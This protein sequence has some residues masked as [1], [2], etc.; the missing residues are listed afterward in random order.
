MKEKEEKWMCT[1]DEPVILYQKEMMKCLSFLLP[2]TWESE[3]ELG[4]HKGKGVSLA[5]W[6]KQEPPTYE[7]LSI[8][9]ALARVLQETEQFLLDEEKWF[10]DPEWIFWD[11]G[12][13][14]LQLI[15]LPWKQEK[16]DHKL[17]EQFSDWLWQSSVI[18]GWKGK[19]QILLLHD[20]LV[21]EK[22][23]CILDKENQ[24][25][26]WSGWLVEKRQTTGTEQVKEKALD[27]LTL[28]EEKKKVSLNEKWKRWRENF[29][30]WF[31]IA[32]R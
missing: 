30:E 31:P 19:E 7:I 13:E 10:W 9:Q 12:K 17:F 3:K 25:D 11:C 21:M 24:P 29:R 18:K 1:V 22:K 20:L 26:A 23:I 5:E 2:F 32:L 14:S 28:P 27:I 15:Y 4:F 16:S 8:V 6:V